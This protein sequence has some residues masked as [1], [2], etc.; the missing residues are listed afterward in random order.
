[1]KPEK[2]N[3]MAKNPISSYDYFYNIYSE[4]DKKYLPHLETIP[5]LLR[6]IKKTFGPEI[7]FVQD[8]K[9][10]SYNDLHREVLRVVG[11]LKAIGLKKGDRI[12]AFFPN[13]YNAAVTLLGIMAL[14]AVA[15]IFPAQ[16]SEELVLGVSFKYSLSAVIAEDELGQKLELAKG[17]LPHIKFLTYK[18]FSVHKVSCRAITDFES[19]EEACI[20]FSS[21]TTG[22]PKGAILTHL[23][24]LVGT[25]LGT[26]GAA[27]FTRQTY[28]TMLPL[29]HVFGLIRSF[30]TPLYGG[31]TIHF[32]RSIQTIFKDMA[33][34]QPTILILVPALCEIALNVIKRYGF[35]I[36][37][38]KLKTIIAGAATVPPFFIPEYAQYGVKLFPGYGLTESSNLVSGNPDIEGRPSSVGR[39]YPNVETKVVNDELWIKGPNVFKG[40]FNDPEENARSF[41]DGYFKTGDLVSFDEEGFLYITGREKDI[42]V[43]PNGENVSPN[44]IEKH[45]LEVDMIQD[46]L[47]YQDADHR[48]I[49]EIFPRASVYMLTPEASREKVLRQSV[50][51][52]NK[53][54]MNYERIHKVIIR[55]EDFARTPS[56][57]IIRPKNVVNHEQK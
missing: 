27:N 54:L 26:M 31:C 8:G 44:Y 51:A 1:M 23:N 47:V 35:G 57:K 34:V 33:A 45:F 12:G 52:I 49:L 24:L 14:G 18:E 41:E 20:I 48:L 28:F 22:S 10:I 16:L 2:E 32:A 55:E 38:G 3:K 43:L 19:T 39:I 37:G 4:E 5:Q 42:I 36:V 25:Y 56:M 7:A 9:K 21:G 17:K 29:S 30:L 13:C 46:C 15:V 53:K 50:D 11:G 6:Y 40:Y